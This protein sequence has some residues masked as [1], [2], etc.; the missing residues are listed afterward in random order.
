[1]REQV[2]ADYCKFCHS[3]NADRQTEKRLAVQTEIMRKHQPC[4]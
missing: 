4:S 3:F 2:I 1:V